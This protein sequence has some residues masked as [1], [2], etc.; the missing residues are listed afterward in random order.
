VP[1]FEKVL[2]ESQSFHSM[3]LQIDNNKNKTLPHNSKILSQI[4]KK[5]PI[6]IKLI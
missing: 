5:T 1:D 4:G 6:A 3:K 2:K